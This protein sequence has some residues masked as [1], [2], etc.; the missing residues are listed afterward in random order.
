MK[1]ILQL[2]ILLIGFATS[3]QDYAFIE[4]IKK[5]ESQESAI[6]LA[7]ELATFANKDLRLYKSKEISGRNVLKVVFVPNAV[8]DED[9]AN[10]VVS[11]ADKAEYLSFVFAIDNVNE[12]KQYRLIESESK[13]LT[14]FPIWQ[15]YFK[16]TA[17][18]DKTKE[19]YSSQRLNEPD[20]NIRY[21]FQNQN[22]SWTIR[23]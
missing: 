6:S 11:D 1:N 12:S 4:K 5:L 20:K 22:G 9:I 19:D 3:A 10:Y 16:P 7:K 21:L 15:K 18:A 13:Y 8:K 2:A 14:I 23:G 17:T